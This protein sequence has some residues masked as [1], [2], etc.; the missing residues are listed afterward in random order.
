MTDDRELQAMEASLAALQ[1]LTPE[2]R[3][4]VIGWL[5]AKLDVAAPKHVDSEAIG[6]I[7][8]PGTGALG[9]IK[10]FLKLKRPGDDVARAT[11]LAYHLAHGGG[12]ATFKTADLNNA[13]V[14]AALAS[15]NVSRAVSNSQRAGYLTTAGKRGSYQITSTGEALVEAMPDVEAVKAVRAQGTRRRRKT[16][17]NQRTT[18][19]ASTA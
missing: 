6:S 3:H 7:D 13:R 17:A 12:R 4:R 9:T 1:S 16:A 8:V 2:E 11:A 15:F 14:D 19:R 5:A 10:E 18:R